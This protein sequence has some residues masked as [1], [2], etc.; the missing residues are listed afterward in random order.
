MWWV[1]DLGRGASACRVQ[2]KGAVGLARSEGSASSIGRASD[3]GSG[4][5]RFESS[6]DRAFFPPLPRSP[7]PPAL[8]R[9]FVRSFPFNTKHHMHVLRYA[10][11]GN[12][13]TIKPNQTTPSERIGAGVARRKAGRAA[14]GLLKGDEEHSPRDHPAAPRL[15]EPL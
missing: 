1:V 2:A 10:Y 12:D 11:Q 15:S 4:G 3:Y 5:W 9:S 6:V 8:V 14:T 7:F 13:P